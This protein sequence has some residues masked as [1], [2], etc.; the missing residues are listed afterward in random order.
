QRRLAAAR[1]ADQRRHLAA[2]HAHADGEQRLLGPVPEVELLDDQD[3]VLAG[4]ALVDDG[5]DRLAAGDGGQ[6]RA[7][8][9]GGQGLRGGRRAV[10]ENLRG[11][12]DRLAHDRRSGQNWPPWKRRRSRE[13]SQMAVR[14]SR[15]TRTISNRVVVKTIGRAASL[16]VLW[17]PTS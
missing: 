6:P 14:L 15:A 10:H 9:E 3:V 17:N 11:G 12:R 7:A 13:R 2:R 16:S 5:G 1:W 8:L 4:D